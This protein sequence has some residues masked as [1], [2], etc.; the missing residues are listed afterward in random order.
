MKSTNITDVP[1]CYVESPQDKRVV[2]PPYHINELLSKIHE[3][4][5]PPISSDGNVYPLGFD[6]WQSFERCTRTF[7]KKVLKYNN[8]ALVF[9]MGSSIQGYRYMRKRGNELWFN[10]RSDYD[11]VI[12]SEPIFDYIKETYPRLMKR[13]IQRTRVI[14]CKLNDMMKD[15][16]RSTRNWPRTVNIVFL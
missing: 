13:K 3:Y 10:E 7:F 5:P 6:S 15:L 2:R 4:V 8:Q 1:V 12:C 9:F 16:Y 11:V 14:P